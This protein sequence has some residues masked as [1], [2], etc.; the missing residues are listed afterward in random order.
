M[1]GLE[2][3]IAA[4]VVELSHGPSRLSS[5]QVR[6]RLLSML[7]FPRE[8]PTHMDRDRDLNDPLELWGPTPGWRCWVGRHDE[9]KPL[10][11]DE[12]CSC[13]CGIGGHGHDMEGVRTPGCDCGHEGTGEK[14]HA[15]DCVWRV[16][17]RRMMQQA[18]LEAAG[19]DEE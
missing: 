1:K 10:G 17:W 6:T 9:C 15:S 8:E 3:E 14:W 2:G 13:A 16:N 11:A 19:G 18:A 12:L 7:R 4:Y 5:K